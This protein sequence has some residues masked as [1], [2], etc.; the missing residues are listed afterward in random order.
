VVLAPE[1][2]PAGLLPSA[3]AAGACSPHPGLWPFSR[4]QQGQ[5]QEQGMGAAWLSP[6]GG[7]P[8]IQSAALRAAQ[9]VS[10]GLVAPAR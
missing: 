8:P 2:A 6:A 3:V 7:V 10:G 4:Q 9:G 1:L 5:G